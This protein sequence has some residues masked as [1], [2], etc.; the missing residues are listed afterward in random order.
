MGTIIQR[1]TERESQSKEVPVLRLPYTPAS[2]KP[3]TFRLQIV[4]EERRMMLAWLRFR[5]WWYDQL[6]NWQFHAYN[7]CRGLCVNPLG[8][9]RK[10]F[11]WI[12]RQVFWLYHRNRPVLRYVGLAIQQDSSQPMQRY[13]Y[14]DRYSPEER[15]RAEAE[16]IAKFIGGRVVKMEPVGHQFDIDWL[17]DRYAMMFTVERDGPKRWAEAAA[18]L[19]AADVPT[20]GRI[21]WPLLPRGHERK[22]H[23][24]RLY[25]KLAKRWSTD[26]KFY[27]G[28]GSQKGE[29]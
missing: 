1:G 29:G 5:V 27:T 15:L 24:A 26:Q 16:A 9:R 28:Y 19:D 2:D 18:I 3:F 7:Y 14:Q 11:L 20:E 10:I 6:R 22:A 12:W 8:R 17:V 4:G 23:L 25:G 13:V 21:L